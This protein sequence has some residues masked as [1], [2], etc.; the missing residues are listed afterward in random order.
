[1]KQSLRFAV[2]TAVVLCVFCSLS[3]VA[4]AQEGKAEVAGFGGLLHVNSFK[5][6]DGVT[7]GAFGFSGGYFVNKMLLLQAELGIGH[8]SKDKVGSTSET[9]AFGPAVVFALKSSQKVAPFVRGDIDIV[10]ASVAN[11]GETKVGFGFGGG[12]RFLAGKNWGVR[13]EFRF[14]KAPDMASSFV[15]DAGIF[16][17]F[18]K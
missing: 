7:G 2:W 1:M 9:F 5:G 17:N 6:A 13:P 15:I 14:V 12:V 4:F 8:V 11:Q 16:Y 18:G 10:H 3:A